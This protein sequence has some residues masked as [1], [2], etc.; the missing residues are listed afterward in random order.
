MKNIILVLAGILFLTHISIAQRT[1]IQL[2]KERKAFAEKSIVNLKEGVLV[3]RLKTNQRKIEALQ[4]VA[5]NSKL[6]ERQRQRHQKMLDNTIT[7][8]DAMNAA[9]ANMFLDSFS[10][11]PVYVMYDTSTKS[12]SNGT[13]QGIF[14]NEKLQ[15]DASIALPAD[16]PI[17]LVN[18]KKKS[19]NF[20]FD[21]LIMRGL[22]ERLEDPFPYYI[23]L[24]ASWINN[25]NTPGA[26]KSV[27]KLDKRLHRFYRNT[28]EKKENE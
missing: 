8:R 20:P 2:P 7:T 24:R 1:D 10:F 26:A 22:K 14:L 13:N 17:F 5:N 12:L 28:I 9:I 6:K 3:V 16:K 27:I 18:Y 4:A 15:P 25:V 23:P 11:C 21:V 19:A